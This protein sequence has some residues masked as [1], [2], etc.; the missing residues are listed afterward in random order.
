MVILPLPLEQCQAVVESLELTYPLYAN[1]GWS[2]FED[3]GTGHVLYAPKQ[4]WIG[5]DDTGV[6]RYVWRLGREGGLGRVP[7]AV[8]A[9]DAFEA[10]LA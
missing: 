4:S 6:V 9:L 8:E 2:V 1:P 10:S 5:I 7:L 3:Y